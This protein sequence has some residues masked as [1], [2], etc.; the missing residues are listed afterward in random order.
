[1]TVEEAI[2]TAIEYEVRIRDI[3]QE[4]ASAV[5][6]A[7]GK[8]IFEMLGKD[9]QNHVDYLESILEQLHQTGK[10]TPERLDSSIPPGKR[11]NR[12]PPR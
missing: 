1:M 5:D 2:Q 7:P 3:Y 9:E 10:I 11:S 8:R 4:A 6:E 12:K